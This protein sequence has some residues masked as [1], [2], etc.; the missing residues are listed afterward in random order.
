MGIDYNDET[1][2]KEY[3]HELRN[4]AQLFQTTRSRVFG[5][6]SFLN[7]WAEHQVTRY[8]YEVFCVNVQNSITRLKTMK[9]DYAQTAPPGDEKVARIA[10]F[11]RLRKRLGTFRKYLR[12]I[13]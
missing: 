6:S 9:A 10:K 3:S 12:Q 13:Y 11:P 1:R 2:S 4:T 7:L 8:D 5:K